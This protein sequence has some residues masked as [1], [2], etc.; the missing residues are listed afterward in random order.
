MRL[1]MPA[2][3]VER[4]LQ[5]E[6][7]KCNIKPQMARLD[8]IVARW[9]RYHGRGS[10][11]L[12]PRRKWNPS[13]SATSKEKPS[14]R[15]SPAAVTRAKGRAHCHGENVMKKIVVMVASAACVMSAMLTAQA[16][17]Q[18]SASAP[19]AAM[20]AASTPAAP[21]EMHSARVEEHIKRLHAA[22]KI[23]PAQ[24][25]QWS[26]VAQVMRDNA[27]AT[28]ALI[29]KR[30]ENIGTMT[31]VDDLKSYGDL[32]QAHADGIKSLEAAF[33]PLY[34]SMSDA[35]KKTADQV[36]HHGQHRGEARGGK[37]K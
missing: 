28:D 27:A 23:T 22:L 37:A 3:G 31:A 33:E 36:F 17:A 7:S 24:E 26:K 10:L 13:A 9:L 29:R 30:M 32:A 20:G 35:Q 18:T 15:E 1:D 16:F 21:G 12:F 14:G 6:S 25:D 8:R 2:G 4:S 11:A 19:S 34:A 5:D